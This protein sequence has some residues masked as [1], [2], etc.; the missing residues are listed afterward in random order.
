[1]GVLSTVGGAAAMMG[2]AGIGSSVLSNVSNKHIAEQNNA[3]NEKMLQKQLELF[4]FS[5]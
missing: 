1:M 4:S 3:F 5:F 2:A